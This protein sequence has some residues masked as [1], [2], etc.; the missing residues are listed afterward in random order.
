MSY[1]MQD[2]LRD[3]RLSAAAQ[4]ELIEQ[5]IEDG[6]AIVRISDLDALVRFAETRGSGDPYDDDNWGRGEVNDAALM[7]ISNWRKERRDW[8]DE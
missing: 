8:T 4:S 1:T 2:W 3:S 5:A 7:A 6:R